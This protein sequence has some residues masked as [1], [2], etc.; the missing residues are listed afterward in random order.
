MYCEH[1][2]RFDLFGSEVRLLVGSPAQADL[3]PADI[4]ATQAEA[5]LRLLHRRL[6]RFERDSDLSLL[7]ADPRE[8]VAVSSLLALAVRAGT[9]AAEETG[10]LVDPT[11]VDEIEEAGYARSRIGMRAEALDDALAQAP[12]R[13]PAVPRSDQRFRSI[14]VD[15]EGCVVTRPPGVRI[16]TG[17]TSKGLAADVV[18]ARLE[19]YRMHVVDAGGD[20]RIG[21]ID[22][23]SRRVEVE[24]PLAGDPACVFMLAEGAV[25][26]SG[27]KTRIWRRGDRYAHH[28]LDP[29]TG[30]PAWTGVIQATAV[31]ETALRAEALAK[32]ALL[33]GPERG[34]A[35]LEGH[36]GI[37]I[38]DDGTVEVVGRIADGESA[39][40]TPDPVIGTT[41]VPRTRQEAA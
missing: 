32:A 5:F 8:R 1:E 28:L 37:L 2:R 21:G 19:G 11:L 20:L 29:S 23:P 6:T 31:A 14:Q 7:N 38:L 25:A 18:S 24:H 36:G 16:D 9:F 4:A 35:V 13:R 3:A 41:T 17:G 22:P 34:R 30:E 15:L 40:R 26:T 27:L 10:G 12:V 33:S 39:V